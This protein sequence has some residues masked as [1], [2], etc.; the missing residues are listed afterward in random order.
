VVVSRAFINPGKV[1]RGSPLSDPSRVPS[2]V[3]ISMGEILGPDARRASGLPREL[4]AAPSRLICPRG[5]TDG[6]A[7]A[8]SRYYRKQ[9]E[10]CRK[11]ARLASDGEIQ[12]RLLQMAMEYM[13]KAARAEP[14]ED[15]QQSITGVCST[16][17]DPV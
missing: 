16:M 12:V 8:N 3:K 13:A 2:A 5:P 7:M 1:S 10:L 14:M 11:L 6:V 17:P 4:G 9:S 15:G